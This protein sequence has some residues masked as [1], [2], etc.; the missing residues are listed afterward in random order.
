MKKLIPISIAILFIAVIILFVMQCNVSKQCSAPAGKT[1][2]TNVRTDGTNLTIAY[3]NTDTLLL[4]YQ[5]SRDLNEELLKKQE[6]ARTNL[7]QEARAFEREMQDFQRKL[8]NN[9]FLS[10]DRA[11]R[12]QQRLINREQE[13]KDLNAKLSNELM[14]KQQEISAQLLDSI[15]LYLKEMNLDKDYDLI[16]STTVGGTI[17]HAKDGLNITG[18]VLDALNKRYKKK[19]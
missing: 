9:G 6:D 17:L 10:R 8:E 2:S 3:I 19:N 14:T 12:E 1:D 13:L 7:N 4:N 11:E 5:L 16:L 18:E 15:T